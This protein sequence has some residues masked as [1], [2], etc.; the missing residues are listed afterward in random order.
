MIDRH[1]GKIVFECDRCHEVEE[2]GTSDFAEALESIKHEGWEARKV[3]EQWRH[4]CPK[5]K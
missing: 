4:Y 3:G 5:C 1:H 2:P